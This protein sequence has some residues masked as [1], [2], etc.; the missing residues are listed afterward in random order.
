MEACGGST[1]APDEAWYIAKFRIT[2][3]IFQDDARRI[4]HYSCLTPIPAP[5]HDPH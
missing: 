4:S 1:A 3:F 2:P 5:I